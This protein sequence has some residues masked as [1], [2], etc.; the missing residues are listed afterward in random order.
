MPRDQRHVKL[1]TN[2]RNQTVRM[3]VEFGLAGTA[4]IIQRDGDSLMIVPARKRGLSAL[5]DSWES[6]TE[7][8]PA[9]EDQ[10]VTAEDIF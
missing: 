1:F 9:I 2:G 6:L 7:A 4:A 8:S 3:P 10:P 5:L